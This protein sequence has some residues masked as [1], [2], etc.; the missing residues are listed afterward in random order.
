MIKHR[1]TKNMGLKAMAFVFSALLW[2]IVVN[3]DDP[4][5]QQTFSDIP[6]TL[7]NQDIITQQ[8]NVYQVLDGQTV[9][10][11]VSARRSVLQDIGS[12]DI[13]ATAD[14][15][16]MDTDTGLI[17]VEISIAGMTVGRDYQSAESVPN[18]LRIQVEKSGKKVLPLTAGT[19]DV[20]TRDGYIIGN[21]TVNPER[22]TITGAESQIEEIDRAVAYV[23]A[24]GLS[25]D[26]DLT[27][28]LR[29]LD[30][31]GNILD[32]NQLTNNLGEDGI[33]VHLE[34]LGSKSVQ[35][36]FG[37]SG[38]PAEGYQYVGVSSEPESVVV[39]GNEEVLEQI[40]SID[41]PD[42]EISVDGATGNVEASIDITPYLP[43][44]TSLGAEA[45]GMVIA[46]AMIEEEG[47]RTIDFLVSSV[48]INNLSDS[49]QVSY[50][51]DAEA[52]LQFRG[53][54][55]RLDTLDISNAVSV[56]LSSYTQPGTYEVPVDVI[57]PDGITFV[58]GTTVVLTLSEKPDESSET[59]PGTGG[60]QEN[61]S[62]TG[63]QQVNGSGTDA[64]G[65]QENAEQQE[66]EG[67]NGQ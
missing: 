44:G 58:E 48:K 63:D 55:G 30:R 34:I 29:L 43:E 47:M 25:K 61:G 16:E 50:Q 22:V 12:E 23:S 60:Q 24:S 33:T 2:L 15:R 41:I 64:S 21:T 59:D 1:L 38:T 32:Q 54:Q 37:V 27:A 11:L 45:T 26:T 53:E 56:D 35:L 49:L 17:P 3:V 36:N 46:T 67:Q 62:G 8:G 20:S 42:S 7:E 57:V 19:S 5:T 28:E 65:Q 18:N 66:E 51:P 4:V 9:T 39:Y 40:D 14:V 52:A 10:A 13:I 31:N 6:V